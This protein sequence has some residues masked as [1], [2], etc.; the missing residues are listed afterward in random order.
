MAPISSASRSVNWP[1]PGMNSSVVPSW[2]PTSSHSATSSSAD[3]NR[4][5]TAPPSKSLCVAAHDDEN[6][7]PP[8]A[9]DVPRRSRI[10]S[11]SSAVASRSDAAS[12]IT[13]RRIA[14]CPTRNPVFG[15]RRPS[16]RSRYEPNEV[17]SQSH[18]AF[19]VAM[20]MPSTRASMCIR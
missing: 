16:R 5:G 18:A 14:E 1:T 15:T 20:G 11:T 6:P 9:I 19:R 7:R 13:T 3:A 8:S 12:P 2:R 10:D 17:Q 4:D